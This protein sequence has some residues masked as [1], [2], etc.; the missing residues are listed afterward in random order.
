VRA[1]TS[2]TE[3]SPSI[4]IRTGGNPIAD[5]SNPTPPEENPDGPIGTNTMKR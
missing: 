2:G 3:P 4:R 5:I 1:R